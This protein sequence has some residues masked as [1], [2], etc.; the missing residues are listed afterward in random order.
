MRIYCDSNIFRIAS[1][2]HSLHNSTIQTCLNELREIMIFPFSE[3]HI[4]DLRKST[5]PYLSQNLIDIE[6]FANNNFF[7]RD[8]V[9][10]TTQIFLATP[11]EALGNYDFKAFDDFLHNPSSV[12]DNLFNFEGAELM[13]ET[14]DKLINTPLLVPRNIPIPN[15]S[16]MDEYVQAF[17][18]PKSLKD[19]IDGMQNSA[20]Y[21]EDPKWLHKLKTTLRSLYGESE[22]SFDQWNAKIDEQVEKKGVKEK[23][24]EKISVGISHYDEYEKYIRMYAHLEMT[25]ITIEKQGGK[26]KKF[27]N[28]SLRTDATHSYFGACCDYLVSNDTGVLIKSSILYKLLNI[29]TKVLSGQ[30]LVNLTPSLKRNEDTLDSLIKMLKH[31][32]KHGF[33]IKDMPG[34]GT[35]LIK[36]QYPFFNYFDRIQILSDHQM[37]LFKRDVSITCMYNEIQLITKKLI[38]ILGFDDFQHGF[39][40]QRDFEKIQLDI[41]IRQWTVNDLIISTKLSSDSDGFNRFCLIL[42]F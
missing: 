33:I 15:N 39:L 37:A 26:V 21:I 6:K 12:F 38:Q 42:D 4:Y 23:I 22:Y 16:A 25:G 35:T 36:T 31:H 3:G 30:D 24:L 41:I 19:I 29:P 10:N 34:A 8:H 17:K 13:K 28:L 18:S 40:D 7:H 11:K 14:W 5:E 2:S 27:D 32:I 9:K 1:E 20:K